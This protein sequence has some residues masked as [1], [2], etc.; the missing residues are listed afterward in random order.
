MSCD[1]IE[2]RWDDVAKVVPPSMDQEVYRNGTTVAVVAG[3]RPWFIERWVEEL[4]RLSGQRVDWHFAGGRA[5]VAALGDVAAVRAAVEATLEDLRTFAAR[6]V[7]NG[8]PLTAS[9]A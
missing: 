1:V 9:L 7:D 5:R 6:R 2:W 8:H 4:R 3:P